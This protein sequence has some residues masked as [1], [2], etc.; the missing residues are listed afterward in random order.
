MPQKLISKESKFHPFHL[1]D[2]SPWP[3]YLSLSS[4]CFAVAVLCILGSLK[5]FLAFSVIVF[6]LVL[7]LWWRDVIRESTFQGKHTIEVKRGIRLGM[8]LFIMSEVMFFFSFFY[9]LFFLALNPDVTLGGRFPPVGLASMGLLGVPL[10]N[11]FLLLSSGVSVTWSHY[12]IL[13]GDVP[14]SLLALAMTLA[15]GTVFLAFQY[16]EYKLSS[17][18]ISDSAYGSIFYLMTGFHGF[19]VMVGVV[20][21]LVMTVRLAKGHLNSSHHTGFELSAWY[22]HFVDVVWLLLFV[23]L[24][25]WLG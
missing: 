13:R 8:I 1:V 5:G 24:Y 19:H 9:G 12:E 18:S 16:L 15:L 25:W 7:S 14:K 3:L 20:F 10:L 23:S 22:W 17:F 4:L 11:S 6:V 21:I 2:F